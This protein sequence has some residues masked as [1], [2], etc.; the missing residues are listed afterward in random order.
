MRASIWRSRRRIL[1]LCLVVT[2]LL[3]ATAACGLVGGPE[4]GG[5]VSSPSLGGGVSTGGVAVGRSPQG[6]MVQEEPT[7]LFFTLGEGTDVPPPPEVV[8]NV[9]G[10]P[11]SEDDLA[12]LLARLPELEASRA[13]SKSSASPPSPS[14]RPGPGRRSSSPSRPR[15]PARASSPRPL[16]PSRSCATAPSATCPWPPSSP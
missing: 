2:M 10:E 9:E 6:G 7:G 1:S 4:P 3:Q 15:N 13:T 11:L 16:G 12:A 5:V 8:R 14:A